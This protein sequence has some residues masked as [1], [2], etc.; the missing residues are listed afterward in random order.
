M[1]VNVAN[2]QFFQTGQDPSRIQWR[3]VNTA[4]FQV[5]YPQEFEKEAQR[6]LF[7]LSKAYEHGSKSMNFNPR[8]ISV[9][10]HTHT[11]NSNG[12]V[13]WAP[14][15]MELYTTPNQKIYSQD[16]LEQLALHEFRHLV[17]LDKIESELPF[18]LKLIFGE[19][20]TAMVTGLYLPLWFLEGDAVVTETA[21]SRSGRGRMASFSMEYRAQL[22][23]KGKYSYD[24]A[25]LGSYKDFVP[26]HY[27]LG[28]WMVGMSQEKYGAD[29]W[30]GVLGNIGRRP[31]S[32]TPVNSV[33]KRQT[34]FNTRQLYDQVFNELTEFWKP[35]HETSVSDHTVVSPERKSYTN[36]LYPE[37]YHDSLIIAYRTSLDDIARFVMIGPD[38]RE[39]VLYTPGPVYEESV[40]IKGHLIVWAERRPDIR[41]THA[42]KTIICVYDIQT[43]KKHELHPGNKLV[44]PAVSPDLK[45]F[46]AVETDNENN[47]F[48]SVFDLESGILRQRFKTTDNQY[49]FTPVWDEKGERLYVVCLSAKGKYMASHDLQTKHLQ[50]LTSFT[51]GNI[52]NSVYINNQILFSAD[53]TGKDRLYTFDIATSLIHN[54][55]DPAFGADY[56][57]VVNSRNQFLFSN[58]TSDGYQLAL[59]GLKDN[60]AMAEVTDISLQS[61]KLADH[62]ASRESG[63]P[64]FQKPD[65]V[66]YASRPYSKAGNLFNFHSWAPAYIDIDNYAIRPGVSLFSQNMLGTADTRF[67]YDYDVTN[68]I[69][70]YRADFN[71]YGWFPELKASLTYGKGTTNYFKITNSSNPNIPADTVAMRSR[72]NELTA[73]LGA[74]L[75]F[76]LSK[77]KYSTGLF[78]E[79]NYSFNHV[80]RIDQD[81]DVNLYSGNY[82]ALSYRFYYYHLLR[83]SR[84]NLMPRWGQQVDLAYKHTPFAGND[85]GTLKGIQ[86][87]VY[88]PGLGK[89]SG[90]RIYQG[91]QEKT[92]SQSFGFSNFVRSPRGVRWYQNNRMYSLA[93]D[94]RMPLVYPDL[95]IGKL[96]YLNRIKTSLFYDYAWY[97]VPV[98]DRNHITIPNGHQ[99]MA[100]SLG[101]DLTSDLHVLRFFAPLEVGIRSVY[102]P[103]T[104]SFAFNLLFTVDFNGF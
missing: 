44:S 21:L 11:A 47:F 99:F 3:Q 80:S 100:N 91:F 87:V 63:I 19:Q 59:T 96:V 65:S 34:G 20:A 36:Y 39:R 71:Y 29:L 25:Y 101:M 41:W 13:A 83:Q 50:Q 9:V 2:A 82:H 37:F 43:G 15:R 60:N 93:A 89:N 85:F 45:S 62:L 23:E 56:P 14:K 38:R 51:Y 53:F 73:Q 17:Q 58:Y 64:G 8:S 98:T 32:I 92:F 10:L 69:G 102:L 35:K 31:L 57:S 97:S 16:W 66:G 22:A 67:G 24:K 7:V 70:R 18:L 27:K 33:L 54:V 55:Y 49:F 74:S 6:L 1:V 5:I 86:G 40:S 88:F 95:S 72:W 78:P 4:N 12:L 61:D 68:K 30:S 94:Y 77:G 42:D 28:Y 48:L 52:K 103:Q 75:P 26:D 76:N 90:I 104:S 46:A 79:I 81:P 84:Q